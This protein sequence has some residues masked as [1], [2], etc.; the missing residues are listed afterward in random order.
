MEIIPA[1][2]LIEGKCV[3]LVKGD[4]DARKE[5]SACPADM[6]RAFEDAG[7]RRLHIVDLDGAKASA[8]VNLKV[9]EE[10]ASSTKLDIEWGGGLK[11]RESVCS[12]F[13]AGV[14]RA[15]C[16]SVAAAD[17]AVFRS[18]LDEF[19]PARMILGADVR[20]DKVATHGWLRDSGISV[21]DLIAGFMQDGLNQVICT[22]IDR[23][24]MLQGPNIPLYEKLM[25]RFPSVAFT[26]SGGVGCL[27]DLDKA[28]AAGIPAAIVGKAFYENKIELKNILKWQ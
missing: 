21:E 5:Y 1:I 11:S 15:I 23:D 20:G 8:P 18:W 16:G 12:V 13:D 22:D 28:A 10:I 4:Y 7:A 19:G 6:A 27:A 24:G 2:D 25:K 14:S 3:R 9:A 17:P 26:L